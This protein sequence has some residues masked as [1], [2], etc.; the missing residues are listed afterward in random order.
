LFFGRNEECGIRCVYHGWKFDVSGV[1]VDMPSEQADSDLKTKVRLSAYPTVDKGGIIWAYLGPK[2]EMPEPPDFEWLRAPA[3]HRFVSKTLER[4]NYLERR[5]G[6]M[7][8][9]SAPRPSVDFHAGQRRCGPRKLA[10]HDRRCSQ[11]QEPAQIPI[12]LFR[13]AP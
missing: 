11:D 13:N 8:R 6:D 9:W 5:P 3:T 12:T 10:T 1:C 2:E 7:V 4:A